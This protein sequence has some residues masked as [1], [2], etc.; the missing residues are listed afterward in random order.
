MKKV[1][2]SQKRWKHL[3][4]MLLVA[5]LLVTGT[6]DVVGFASEGTQEQVTAAAEQSQKTQEKSQKESAQEETAQKEAVQDHEQMSEE[7]GG[8]QSSSSHSD[9]AVK[10]EN[11]EKERSAAGTTE[12]SETEEPQNN[13]QKNEVVSGAKSVAPSTSKVREPDKNEE[14]KEEKE[15]KDTKTEYIYKSAS[16]YAK[17]TLKDAEALSDHAELYVKQKKIENKIKNKIMNKAVGEEN[18]Q[19]VDSLK[20]YDFS[21]ILSGERVDPSESMQVTLSNLGTKNTQN[22]LIY[23]MEEDGQVKKVDA[24]KTGSD[25]MQF[26][27]K[28]LASYV[29]LTYTTVSDIKGNDIT[30]LYP[31]MITAAQTQIQS[32]ENGNVPI[33]FWTRSKT[34]LVLKD[35]TGK[36][37]L[38]WTW[39][40]IADIDLSLENDSQ[41]WN[42]SRS[43]G[44]HIATS[45]KN[46]RVT[47][48][49]GKL[50]DSALWKNEGKAGKDT[51]ITRIRGEF[52]IT[53]KNRSKYAY[54]LKTVTDSENIYAKDNMFVF[55]YPKDTE[56][57]DNNYMDYLAFWTGA[58]ADAGTFHERTA[59]HYTQRTSAKGLSILTDGWHMTTVCNNAGSIIANTDANDYYIDV[60][61]TTDSSTGGMYRFTLVKDTE[62]GEIAKD[63]DETSKTKEAQSTEQT[64]KAASIIREYKSDEINVTVTAENETDLPEDAKLQVTA[65]EKDNK[66]TAEKYE[67]V[68]QQLIDKTTDKSYSIAGFLAYDISFVDNNGNKIEPNGKVQVSIEY[69]KTAI[70]E[71]LKN[72]KN[73]ANTA[74][75]VMHLEEDEEGKVK[76]IVDMSKNKQL[77]DIQTNDDKEVKTVEFETE[78]FS[79]FTITWTSNTSVNTEVNIVSES[80]EIIELQDSALSNLEVS[81][82]TFNISSITSDDKYNKYCE[83]TDKS[84]KKYQFDK[85]VVLDNDK[86]YNRN[87]G[88]QIS[89]LN[90]HNNSVWY[91]SQSESEWEYLDDK[92]VYFV[93]TEMLSEVETVDSA[94]KGIKIKMIDLASD[95][96]NSSLTNGNTSISLGGGYGNGTIKKNLLERRLGTDGYPIAKNGAKSLSG[97]FSGATETN[98][99]FIKSIYANTGYYEYSS[100]EN[101]AYLDTSSSGSTK[102]FKVYKQIGTPTN[103]NQYF[104]K[105]GNFMPYNS[106]SAGRFSTNK[107]LYDEDGKALTDTAPRKEEKLYLVNGTPNYYFGMEVSANFVQQKNGQVTQNGKKEPMVYEFN[108]D[109]DMWVFIDGTLVLDIGG[110]HDAHSGKINF[111]TGV[112]SWKDCQTGKTP[113][114]ESTT[115]KAL[116]KASGYFPDGTEWTEQNDG[117]ADN[118]F[119]GN[120]FKDYSS[121][122]MRMF[123]FERG[124]G[125]SNLHMKFNLPV[126]PEGSVEVKKELSN[127]DKEK[128]A[129]VQFKFKVYAQ[130]VKEDGTFEDSEDSY[131]V[132]TTKAKMTD[133]KEVTFDKDGAFYLKPGQKATFSGLKDNQKY[134]VEEIGVKSE[135]YDDIKINDVS[136]TEYTEKQDEEGKKVKDI[137]TSKVEAENR[138]LVV[139]TNNCSAANKRELRITKAMKEGQTTDDTFS[140]KIYLTSTEGQLVPYVGSYYLYRGNGDGKIY[141][142]NEN[143]E[144][145]ALESGEV[146]VAGDTNSLGEIT[147]IPVGYTVSITQILSGTEFKVEE[148]KLNSEKYKV[149]TITVSGCKDAN[150]SNNIATGTIELRNDASV[151]VTNRKNYKVIKAEKKW[152]DS[153]KS[154]GTGEENFNLKPE[155]TILG[156]Y[157]QNA[158][159]PEQVKQVK[160]TDSTNQWTCE[161]E[162]P[163]N[164][165]LSDYTIKEIVE[166]EQSTYSPANDKEYIK[167]GDYIYQVTY[168]EK[169][170]TTEGIE[171]KT[172][173]VVNTLQRG[174]I[175]ITK[176]N[177]N[178]KKEKLGGAE[179]KITGPDNYKETVTTPSE[180]V[181]TISDLLPGEYVITETKAPANYNLLANPITVVVG[182]T[183]GE[184]TSSGFTVVGDSNT[185][186]YYDLKMEITNNKLFDMPA[187][188]GGFRAT[189][190]GVGIMIIAGGWYIIRRRRRII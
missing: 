20:A 43:Y 138:R 77:K 73:L 92:K 189:I 39:S 124:A 137:R 58:S 133:G 16:I 115:I 84:G 176:I 164:H 131:E 127:T 68:K 33:E 146:E 142:K 1:K 98:H 139:F 40:D 52:T 26:M 38:E 104:Y 48:K 175:E 111:A 130:K 149:P 35:K 63:L 10:E 144:L 46:G 121:H 94:S 157:Y 55:V 106:I 177:A 59:A 89:S 44:K 2:D 118:Y 66:N 9:T 122:T 117:Q 82:G 162:V 186:Y 15:E 47:A 32:K 147:G 17:V 61:S 8:Q 150:T 184:S 161:F 109:D 7:A 60:I 62:G 6:P 37:A 112:V 51:T 129:N 155:S 96:Q 153:K 11:T 180:G 103:E 69:N 23:Q 120:T 188:G 126:I 185:H 160:A 54:T 42:G 79:T 91:Q 34:P 19:L 181:I 167:L 132:L 30:T 143:G 71:E 74:V 171:E 12:R 140:F 78:S 166:K 169:T 159:Q 93:Y 100:F 114:E 24:V 135:E 27:T 173:S 190:F 22:T 156:L 107:N 108:G 148:I 81:E 178:N 163:A 187:A 136:Y 174:S 88:T 31:A 179:F 45:L 165:N 64:A 110:I 123:Y 95:S 70:P 5:A 86:T 102:D 168:S 152:K 151:L 29:I 119:K 141:Y 182:T 170:E 172:V 101:Y 134:Y 65:I 116:F 49:D 113:V 28:R 128:Y 50:Y 83:L 53:D 125:A 85:A 145:R 4:T 57:T 80:G 21:F 183:E 13:K 99:L 154:D 90:L 36:K 97:L 158:A 3:V 56:L 67:D 76:N 87:N 41:V 75:T 18:K 14:K 72:D 25:A 105:R